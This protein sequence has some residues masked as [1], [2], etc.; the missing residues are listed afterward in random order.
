MTVEINQR[1]L[2]NDSG[3][4]MRRVEGGETFLVTR[5]GVPLAELRPVST[6]RPQFTRR[7]DALASAA[8]L[9]A[10]DAQRFRSEL[11]ELAD[12][13]APLG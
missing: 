6:G 13:S 10:V 5:N 4:V 9:P 2:R 12:A 1:Q 7:A 8:H 3:E 11:D